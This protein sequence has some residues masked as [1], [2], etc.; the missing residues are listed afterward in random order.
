MYFDQ[1]RALHGAYWHNRFGYP[2]SRGCVNLS[3]ADSNW[4]FQWAQVG[5]WV[6]VHDPSG[7]TPTDPEIFGE[8]GA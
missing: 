2:L 7:Q 5:E 3:T 1:A 6:Y 8:G 4:L